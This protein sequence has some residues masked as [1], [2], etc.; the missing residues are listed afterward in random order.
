MKFLGLQHV[1]M[2]AYGKSSSKT[3]ANITNKNG[4]H[5]NHQ[6]NSGANVF[7]AE[8]RC[9]HILRRNRCHYVVMCVIVVVCRNVMTSPFNLKSI[10]RK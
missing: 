10:D 3:R 7:M 2:L 6:F 4:N 5:Q 9:N 8:G 1:Q